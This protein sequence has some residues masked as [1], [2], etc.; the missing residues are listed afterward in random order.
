MNLILQL[1]LDESFLVFSSGRPPAPNQTD[2]FI[3]FRNP[4]GGWCEPIDLGSVLSKNVHGIEARFS[5]D[6]KT[7]YYSNALN[8]AGESIQG[9]RYIWQVDISGL[10]KGHGIK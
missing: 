6:Y 3:V 8:A 1:H 10:L 2:L 7:L 5:P 9:N 4:G